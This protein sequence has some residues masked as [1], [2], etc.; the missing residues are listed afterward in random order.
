VTAE[1]FCAEYWGREVLHVRRAAPEFYRDLVGLEEVEAYLSA[2]DRLR[3]IDLRARDREGGGIERPSTLGAL[4]AAVVQGRSLQLRK[5]EAFL[6]PA[7]PALALLRDMEAVLQHPEDSLS[8]HVSPA[9]ANGLGPH[10]DESEIFTLQISGRKRWRFYHQVRGDEP[11]AYRRQELGAPRRELV[12][13]PG[14]LLYHPRGLVHE[15]TGEDVP[16]FSLTIVFLPITW[17]AMLEALVAGAARLPAFDDSMPAGALLAAAPSPAIRE[18][19]AARLA[20]VRDE[21]ARLSPEALLDEVARRAIPRTPPLRQGLL[22]DLFRIDTISSETPLERCP[23]ARTHVD[24]PL[25]DRITLRVPGFDPLALPAGLEPALRF[26]LEAERPF[27]PAEIP[28]L[29]GAEAVVLGKILMRGGVL[30]FAAPPRDR[31][32]AAG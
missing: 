32:P 9:G 31:R 25:D 16:S 3:G 6:H 22:R 2:Q 28:G 7:S 21:L 14:D 13:E 26:V 10:H 18:G 5:M 29:T 30:R 1:R 8:C 17:R 23:E 4:Y 27:R 19:F 12:L 11:R 24:R 15:V 20:L